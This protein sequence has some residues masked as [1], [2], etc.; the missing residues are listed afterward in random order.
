MKF[1]IGD[2]VEWRYEGSYACGQVAGF[3]LDEYLILFLKYYM[4]DV[5]PDLSFQPEYCKIKQFNCPE[6]FQL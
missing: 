3:E 5:D 1:K 2:Y 6:Y 4:G